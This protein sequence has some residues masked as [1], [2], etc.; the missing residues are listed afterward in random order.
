MK[1]FTKISMGFLITLFSFQTNA[2]TFGIKGG[3]NLANMLY[4][5]DDRTY[6]DNYSMNP[7]FHI[8]LTIDVSLND[9]L[10]FESG[11]LL[12]TK[13]MNN[14]HEYTNPYPY[15]YGGGYA[16]VSSKWSSK[17]LRKTNLYYLDVPLT[18]KISHNIGSI[19]KIFGAVG[20]YIDI[21]LSGNLKWVRESNGE[22]ETK[23]F[24]VIWENEFDYKRLDM[25]LSFGGGVEIH[26]I[27]TGITYDLGLS[28]IY[29]TQYIG[30]TKKNRVLK[31]SV[32]YMFGN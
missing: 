12:S 2:Q 16:D 5:D 31:F 32:G 20:P 18:I 22:K 27:T 6:S 29:A 14:D 10:S 4:K 25:G 1:I 7:G 13:G 19:L 3:L 26:S 21:G 30:P 15:G 28:N 23:E 17:D 9:F 8:G 24:D 11:L